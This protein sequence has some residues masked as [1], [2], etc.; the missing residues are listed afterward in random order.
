[1]KPLRTLLALASIALA[2]TTT[3]AWAQEGKP[4]KP[5]PKVTAPAA[6][7][8][9]KPAAKPNAKPAAKPTAKT[10]AKPA[11][12]TAAKPAVKVVP[13]PAAEVLTPAQAA[14][15]AIP[16][17][18]VLGV[19]VGRLTADKRVSL[20]APPHAGLYVNRVLPGTVA[21]VAGVQK[22]DVI[23]DGAGGMM[24]DV[25]DVGAALEQ[26]HVGE[27]MTMQ[28]IRR[29]KPQTLFATLATAAKPEPMMKRT[30]YARL[31]PSPA[32][33]SLDG[34]LHFVDGDFVQRRIDTRMRHLK[35]R[36]RSI[37]RR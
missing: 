28:V 31:P 3:T 5:K 9:A 18:G 11:A 27:L 7:P 12:K 1:M 34:D 35:R 26:L 24:R 10:A 17:E 33:A 15:P 37:R 36:V 6:K 23:L 29:G 16:F 20:G 4:A 21:S 30:R 13:T 8:V 32:R 22:G 14:G 2:S 25:S 19:M